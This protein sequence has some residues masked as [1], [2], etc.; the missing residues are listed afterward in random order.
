MGNRRMGL[1]R[2]EKLLESVDRDLDLTNSTLTN[3][4]ITT[5]Q[6]V[7]V[8]NLQAVTNAADLVV[9]QFDGT[10]VA[11]V[12]D[13]GVLPSATGTT[14]SLAAGTGLGLRRRVLT[15]G[16]A[17]NDNVLTLTAADSGAVI[18]VTPTNNLKIKLPLVGTETGIW[19]DIII[20]ANVNKAFTIETS[21]Q[22]SADNITL[23]SVA[24]DATTGDVGAAD[25]DILT[26]TN[27]LAGSRIQL[28]NCAGGAAEKWHA[29]VSSMNTITPTIA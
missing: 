7:K 27:A 3:C 22:D 16:S 14:P 11:R 8:N 15:L 19:F 26:F 20:A 13:G 29:Y 21:G 2:M 9:K 5:T 25:H 6:P 17:N 10:E 18:Y 12:H 28:V 1:G 24:T 4:T 23:F